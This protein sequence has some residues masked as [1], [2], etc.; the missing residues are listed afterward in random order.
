MDYKEI[1]LHG[2][3]IRYFNEEHIDTLS[4]EDIH[5]IQNT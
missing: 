4:I 2:R 3:K 5:K 1:E